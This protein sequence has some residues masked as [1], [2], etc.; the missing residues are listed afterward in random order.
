[1]QLKIFRLDIPDLIYPSV[2][3]TSGDD[4]M[5]EQVVKVFHAV[6]PSYEVI[7]AFYND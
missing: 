1:M 6:D 4:E 3:L 2:A 5:T 7:R